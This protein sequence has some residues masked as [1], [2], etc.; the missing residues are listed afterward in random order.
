MNGCSQFN[1]SDQINQQSFLNKGRK[2]KFILVIP[3][4]KILAETASSLGL[5]NL[6]MSVYGSPVP[7]IRI[8]PVTLDFRGQQLKVTSQTRESFGALDVNFTID[9]QFKNYWFLWK[10]MEI[11]NNSKESGMDEYF[12]N[13]KI[14]TKEIPINYRKDKNTPNSVKFD[15][16]INKR[17]NEP[18]YFDYMTD[19]TLFGLDEY[20]NKKIEFIYKQA[21]ISSLGGIDYNYRN[22]DELEVSVSFDFSQLHCSLLDLCE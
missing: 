7:S 9:N 16:S 20:N 13:H 15:E 4:P 21:F 22:A 1:M 18:I 10:W 14:Y 17:D 3:P 2:D 6:Q 12:N 11:L 8:P 19:L 5:E